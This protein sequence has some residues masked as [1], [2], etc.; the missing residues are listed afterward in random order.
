MALPGNDKVKIELFE[1]EKDTALL[2]SK[3]LNIDEVEALVLFRKFRKDERAMLEAE[4]MEWKG[5]EE[6]LETSRIANLAKGKKLSNDLLDGI[7]TYYL[8]EW[9][10]VARLLTALLRQAREKDE[11]IEDL[12]PNKTQEDS[13]VLKS[14]IITLM[15][16]VAGVSQDERK[17][18]V[19]R[20]FSEFGVVMQSILPPIDSKVLQRKW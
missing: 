8:Q 10:A 3:H 20:L 4:T 17:A 6:Y 1:G 19:Y 7:T 12:M 15:G 5:S 9:L 2:I 11:D 18:F 13:Q 16:K 14:A